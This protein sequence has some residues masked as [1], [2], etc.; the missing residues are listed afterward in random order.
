MKRSLP[1]LPH[2]VKLVLAYFAVYVIWG[3][4]F[5]VIGKVVKEIPPLHAAGIRFTIAGWMLIA[6]AFYRGERMPVGRE[7]FSP[8]VVAF[9]LLVL[10]NGSTCI[11]SLSA[12]SGVIAVLHSLG[13]G[14]TV[15][16]DRFFFH[17]ES[18]GVRNYLGVLVGISGAAL[19]VLT[20]SGGKIS[21][22]VHPSSV[23][24]VLIG[25]SCWAFGSLLGKD[26][27]GPSS[28]VVNSGL[29]MGIAGPVLI[30]IGSLVDW[31]SFYSFSPSPT[32]YFLAP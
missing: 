8:L 29:G 23:V 2:A 14:L 16:L 18:Y 22:Q 24:V 20:R 32:R 5:L 6:W 13:P 3:S 15:F 28:N 1:A 21:F 7:W 27:R 17:K 19:L 9:F 30:I 4:T 31:N 25:V 10:T 26:I 12:P 11:A